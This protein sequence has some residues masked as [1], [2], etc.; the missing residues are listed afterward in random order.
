MPAGSA[1][2][3]LQQRQIEPPALLIEATQLRQ[4]LGMVVD[5]Q[6]EIGIVLAGMDERSR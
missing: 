5:P 1:R 4:R 3:E 2:Q 6:V